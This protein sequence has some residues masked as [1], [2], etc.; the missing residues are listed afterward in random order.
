M[1]MDDSEKLA[2][3]EGTLASNVPFGDWRYI[4]D[5]TWTRYQ[6]RAELLAERLPQTAPLAAAMKQATPEARF[7]VVGDPVFRATLNDTLGEL[8]LG[9]TPSSLARA[10]HLLEQA[11]RLLGEPAPASPLSLGARQVHRI[12]TELHHGWVWCDE[13]E[14]DAWGQG[15]RDLFEREGSSSA[16]R[17]PHANA[18]ATLSSAVSILEELLPRVTRS[19]LDHTHLIAVTD[20]LD[21][22]QWQNKERAFPY[23]SFTT[24]IIPGTV[25]LAMGV[26]G[27]PYKA[28]EHLLHEALHLKW[29][30]FQHSHAVFRKDYQAE[31]SVRVRALWNRPLPDNTNEWPVCRSIAA[32]HV[33]VHLALYFELL[34]RRLPEL[35]ARYGPLWGYD[36]SLLKHEAFE[37][38]RYLGL[39]VRRTGEG[40]LRVAGQRMVAWLLEMLEQLGAGPEPEDNGVHLLLDLYTR[41]STG[42]RL[43]AAS[44]V[45]APDWERA[46][47]ERLAALLAQELD[48]ARQLAASLGDSGWRPQGPDAPTE[49]SLKRLVQASEQ[50]LTRAFQGTRQAVS[51]LLR[52]VPATSFRDSREPGTHQP[53]SELVRRMVESSSLELHALTRSQPLAERAHS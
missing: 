53:L 33:Y 1:G 29:Y 5:C 20:V 9:Q 7:R 12:G 50:E 14:E 43:G 34:E 2:S 27:N 31:Q 6:R 48:T 32:M 10:L 11:T 22:T 40:E 49:E 8:Q 38:A 37:R 4:D 46:R 28:A 21:R 51:Q 13:R 39:A 26:L 24:R 35:E 41:E 30:D 45:A 18:T 3:I 42:F 19:A 17:T 47:R 15:F 44:E 16:L 25:F 23:G 36:P 52:S